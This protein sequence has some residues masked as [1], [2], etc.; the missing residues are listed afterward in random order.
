MSPPLKRAALWSGRLRFC[1]C[2]NA[3]RARLRDR[4]W[5]ALTRLPLGPV[6]RLARDGGHQQRGS[7]KNLDDVLLFQTPPSVVAV[8][9]PVTVVREV[10]F[11]S[12]GTDLDDSMAGL[13]AG[14]LPGLGKASVV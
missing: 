11:P 12:D 1:H 14:E 5:L 6:N 3:G 4:L 7:G 10:P 9:G 13:V 8:T 2:C